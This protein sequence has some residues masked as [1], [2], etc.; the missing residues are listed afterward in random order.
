MF[1]TRS[2]YTT[3]P[4]GRHEVGRH[5]VVQSLHS[6]Y[7][8][9]NGEVASNWAFIVCQFKTSSGKRLLEKLMYLRE[10]G[11]PSECSS[12]SVSFILIAVKH[13]IQHTCLNQAFIILTFPSVAG[14]PK[15]HA[16]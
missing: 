12:T 5:D 10:D 8:T 15:T 4:V 1:C 3:K 7:I 14:R 11:R 6:C 9:I 2:C 16:V 13:F